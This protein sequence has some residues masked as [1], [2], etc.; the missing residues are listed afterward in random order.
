M[1]LETRDE[2][3]ALYSGMIQEGLTLEYKASGGVDKTPSKKEEM[4]KDA[5]AFAN[6]AGPGR[7]RPANAFVASL[8][9][10]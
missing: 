2:L 5:S 7:E 8:Q 6:A 4:A 1:K 10:A 3:E 9:R